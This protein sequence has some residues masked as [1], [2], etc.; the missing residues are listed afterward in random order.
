MLRGTRSNAG[1]SEPSQQVVASV[2]VTSKFPSSQVLVL[3]KC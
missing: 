2:K 3:T 1:K